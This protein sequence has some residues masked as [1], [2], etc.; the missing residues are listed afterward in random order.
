MRLEFFFYDLHSNFFLLQASYQDLEMILSF[1]GKTG[2]KKTS[3]NPPSSISTL[4]DKEKGSKSEMLTL[5]ENVS[6]EN[7]DKSETLEMEEVNVE[8]KDSLH[9]DEAAKKARDK[10]KDGS[11]KK[12]PVMETK[13]QELYSLI[14][15]GGDEARIENFQ[16][17]VLNNRQ[18]ISNSSLGS[19][20]P[21]FPPLS[22][23]A[24]ET[25]SVASKTKMRIIP[26]KPSRKTR[27]MEI[28]SD[29]E[30]T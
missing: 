14:L 15:Q 25:L 6:D 30:E 28:L 17:F 11:P 3:E 12:D 26:P 27:K 16:K 9:V 1:S 5:A 23:V 24:S 8:T 4:V 21:S 22:A 29:D 13:I 10:E 18:N 20:L 19:S 7:C 2:K